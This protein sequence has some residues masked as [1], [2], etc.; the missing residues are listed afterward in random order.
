[1]WSAAPARL[2]PILASL[3][4]GPY[5][6]NMITTTEHPTYEAFRRGDLDL[7]AFDHRAHLEVAWGYLGDGPF[8]EAA[9]AFTRRLRRYLDEAGAADKFHAT[10]TLAFLALVHER[11]V[12]RGDGGSFRGFLEANPDLLDVAVVRERWGDALDHPLARAVPLIPGA[13]RPPA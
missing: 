13:E 11:R 4:T 9:A 1:M 8:Y 12:V 2:G 10:I 3:G 5:L 7:E 6:G